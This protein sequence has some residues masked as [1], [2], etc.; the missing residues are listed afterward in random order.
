VASK[1]IASDAE[2][3]GNRLRRFQDEARAASALNHPN[4]ISVFDVDIE[5]ETPYVFFELLEGE[6]LR[7]KLRSGTLPV[8]KTAGLRGS[9]SAMP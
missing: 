8:R 2:H 7:E 6:A 4:V 3:S 9:R 5:N 1:I